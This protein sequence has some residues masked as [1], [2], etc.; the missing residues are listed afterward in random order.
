LALTSPTKYITYRENDNAGELKYYILQR[1]Y[2]HYTF[3]L[4]TYPVER[5]FPAHQ[6]NG[7]HLWVCFAGTIMGNLIL[8]S[9]AI[10]EKQINCV[11]DDA[12]T[13]FYEHRLIPQAKKY[14]KFK[15]DNFP[16]E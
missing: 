10:Q 5:I 15:Y 4:S 7:Y 1:I 16:N 8:P 12:A 6:I 14:K 2:P 13:W 11:M 9:L 3:E